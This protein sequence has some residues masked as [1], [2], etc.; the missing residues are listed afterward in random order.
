MIVSILNLPV[1]TSKNEVQ[2]FMGIINFVCMFVLDFDL[3]VKEIHNIINQDR[4][5]SWTDDIEIIF[6]RIKKEI[7]FAPVLAKPNFEKD[8]I[9]Y[10]NDIEEAIYAILLQCDDQNNEKL[11]SYMR[12]SLSDGEFKYSYIEKHAFSLVKVVD[13]FLHFILGKHT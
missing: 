4:Y 7:S 3:M 10:T 13:K 11:V 5:F 2:A 1:P 9:I 6:L 8:F 12:Q